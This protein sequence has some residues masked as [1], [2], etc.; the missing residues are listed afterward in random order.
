M[1]L[2]QILLPSG[3]SDEWLPYILGASD[4][5][6]ATYLEEHADE[7]DIGH[8]LD[9]FYYHEALSRFPLHHWRQKSLGHDATKTPLG[10]QALQH[11]ALVRH[12]PV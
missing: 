12:R 5:I 7:I 10:P 4:I 3:S 1:T 2:L 9:W 11:A 8:L 6:K